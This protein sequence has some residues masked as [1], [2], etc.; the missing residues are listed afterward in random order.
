M[1]LYKNLSIH[2]IVKANSCSGTNSACSDTVVLLPSLTL[3]TLI[4]H[5][6]LSCAHAFSS[7]HDVVFGASD[8]MS[9]SLRS[10]YLCCTAFARSLSSSIRSIC[11]SHDRR[12][13]RIASMR[14]NDLDPSLASSCCVLPV[15]T[16]TM[17][18]FAPFIFLQMSLSRHH[19]SAPYVILLGFTPL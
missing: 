12:R 6:F 5:F 19:A 7:S 2:D 15:M 17:R 18:L 14:S 13:A 1:F 4:L 3:F 8:K 11:P 10:S 16:L 9:P